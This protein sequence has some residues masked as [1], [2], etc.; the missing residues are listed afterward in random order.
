[1][2]EAVAENVYFTATG[3]QD[4]YP[5]I[6]RSMQSVPDGQK[7]TDFPIL[8]NIYWPYELSAN[9]GMPDKETNSN[10]IKFED[11]LE[12]LD[13]NNVSHLMLVITGN[14]RKEWYWYVKDSKNWMNQLN[15]LLDGH[16]VYPLQIEIIEEH[17]WATY[18]G[19]VSSVSGI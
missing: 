4:G 3:E 11:A 12:V 16:Q 14:G 2:A 9:N 10:Q 18:H 19:F 1:M 8:I 5:V 7:E 17:D 15:K 6:Y 13:K